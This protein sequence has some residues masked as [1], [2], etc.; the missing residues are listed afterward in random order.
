MREFDTTVQTHDTTH[1]RA[2]Q[3]KQT[4]TSI[5]NTYNS[6]NTHT[7]TTQEYKHTHKYTTVQFATNN[8]TVLH[9]VVACTTDAPVPYNKKTNPATR[10]WQ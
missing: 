9:S 1:T 8:S 5:T 10:V 4:H 3:Y 6:T 7:S 2:K